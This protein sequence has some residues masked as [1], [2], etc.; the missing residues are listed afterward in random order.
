M[1]FDDIFEQGNKHGRQGR[2]GHADNEGYFETSGHRNEESD[3]KSMVLNKLK[4]NPKLKAWLI[5]GLVFITIAIVLLI[6]LLFPAIMKLLDFIG[7]NGIKGLLDSI[8]S[9]SK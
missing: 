7:Q 2:Y 5:A 8:W 1:K 6:I 4:E 9:G 3:V